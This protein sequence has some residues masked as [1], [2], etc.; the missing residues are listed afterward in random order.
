MGCTREFARHRATGASRPARQCS[1]SRP[2]IVASASEAL[3]DLDGVETAH[4]NGCPAA[5]AAGYAW[6]RTR[7]LRAS[8][9]KGHT[10]L[11]LG[12]QPTE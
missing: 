6:R 2:G 11:P 8:K 10:I 3:P 4:C 1:N 12:L 9:L 7:A 5:V